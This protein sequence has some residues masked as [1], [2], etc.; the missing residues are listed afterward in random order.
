[1]SQ[2]D[3]WNMHVRI[4]SLLVLGLL[5]V[6]APVWAVSVK[7]EHL[8]IAATGNGNGEAVNVSSYTT[9]VFQVCCTFTATVNFE[10]SIDGTNFDAVECFSIADKTSRTV[11]PTVRGQWR[12]NMIGMNKIRARIS[13]YVSGTITVDAG[14]ASAGVY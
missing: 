3:G 6:A 14:L 8:Q 9:A 10:A 5:V 7:T 13:G 1:M 2:I 4:I 12:C 11:A